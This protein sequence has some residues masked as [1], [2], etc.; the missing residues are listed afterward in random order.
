MVKDGSIIVYRSR[1][2]GT[3]EIGKA[4]EVT[5]PNKPIWL[6][7]RVIT[8]AGFTTLVE[9]IPVSNMIA[10]LSEINGFDWLVNIPAQQIPPIE[11]Q[12]PTIPDPRSVDCTC[13]LMSNDHALDGFHEEHCARVFVFGG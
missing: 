3:I 10:N 12:V 9:T 2:R 4:W 13:S 1:D 6:D 8:S 7:I 5:N 11:R